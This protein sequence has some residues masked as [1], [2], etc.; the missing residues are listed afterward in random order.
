MKKRWNFSKP[1]TIEQCNN[2][3]IYAEKPMYMQKFQCLRL[4][5]SLV[6]NLPLH[7]PLVP[8]GKTPHAVLKSISTINAKKEKTTELQQHPNNRTIKQ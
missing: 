7:A 2:R 3:T 5:L 1:L 8:K 4:S 6:L